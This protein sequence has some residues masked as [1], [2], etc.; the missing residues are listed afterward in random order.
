MKLSE[1][2]IG[3]WAR[4]SITSDLVENQQ[5]TTYWVEQILALLL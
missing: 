1:M 5:L 3:F 2:E 4:L